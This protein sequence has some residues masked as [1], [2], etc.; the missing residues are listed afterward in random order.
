MPNQKLAAQMAALAILVCTAVLPQAFA[1]HGAVGHPTLYL[2]ENLIEFEGEITAVLWR[3]PHPRMRMSVIDENGEEAIWELELNSSPIGFTRRGI[4][5]DDFVQVGDQVRVAGVVAMFDAQSLGV[6]HYLRPDGR[7]YINGN[8]EL[9]WSNVEFT[10]AVQALDPGKVSA[11]E[12]SAQSIFRV[13]GGPV[14]GGAHPSVTLYQPYLT[15]RGADMAA[16]WNRATDDAELDCRQG[17]PGAMFDPTPIELVDAGDR[18]L[19]LGQEYDIERTIYLNADAAIA[20]PGGSAL[21]HSVGRWDDDTLIVTT[22]HI[23]WPQ[24]DPFGTPQ[25]DQAEYLETF[26]FSAEDNTLH[27]SFTSTDPVMFTQPITLTRQRRWTPGI[28]IVP[29]NCIA[30]WEDDE[31]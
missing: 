15:E 19:V 9:R 13:W 27:Y 31:R 20:E 14:R 28:E 7:E 18:I 26:Q 3:N 10:S 22:T 17:M 12:Q 16:V 4:S 25:S 8:R 24:F 23:N 6:L 29:F 30:K 1:H 2:A 5:A 21:G 11:A